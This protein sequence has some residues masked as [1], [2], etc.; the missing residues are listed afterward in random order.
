MK[1]SLNR[2]APRGAVGSFLTLLSM[3]FP[4]AALLPACGGDSKPEWPKG[5]I[6]MHDTNNYTST[7]MLTIPQI[8][9]ASG[10]DLNVCWDGLMKVL[11]CH[12]IVPTTNDVDN[13]SFLKIPNMNETDVAKALAV[14]QLDPNLVMVYRDHHVDHTATTKCA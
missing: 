6:V 1:A 9:T 4:L 2:V 14:G 11:L 5:N 8:P 10:V 3:S 13:V 12:D 7:T